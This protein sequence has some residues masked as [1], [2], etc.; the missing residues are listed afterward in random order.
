[1]GD[2]DEIT[3]F[4]ES[5]GAGS[6]TLQ[7]MY[8]GNKGM[9]KRVIAE[10][11]SALAYWYSSTNSNAAGLINVSGCDS[12]PKEPLE[13][14]RGKSADHLII[15]I[16]T[17]DYNLTIALDVV[18]CPPVIDGEF[19]VEDPYDIVFGNNSKSDAARDVF[20]SVDMLTGVNNR[21]G[22]LFVTIWM[23]MFDQFYTKTI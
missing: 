4:G 23:Q 7:S 18:R 17:L 1:M 13:C 11:G 15:S 20:R 12:G 14:L 5:A 22:A 2:P 3:I 6:V 8:A 19:I 16:N 10:S 9:F 21:D